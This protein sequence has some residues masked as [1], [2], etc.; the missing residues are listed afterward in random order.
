MGQTP[1]IANALALA[2]NSRHF[3]A[4]LRIV[5]QWRVERDRAQAT[6]FSDRVSAMCSVNQE[7]KEKEWKEWQV[8]SSLYLL[9]NR[10]YTG[11]QRLATWRTMHDSLYCL[12]PADITDAEAERWFSWTSFLEMLGMAGLNQESSGGL[13]ALHAHLN[14]SCAPNVQVRLY[15]IKELIVYNER[16]HHRCAT[17]PNPTTFLNRLAFY[18][19]PPN[20]ALIA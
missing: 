15:T 3:D 5:A 1:A 4:V 10:P 18:R 9:T 20:E 2:R 7:T 17:Y 14:H 8:A 12:Q 16:A 11:E 13:Y 19:P 6:P